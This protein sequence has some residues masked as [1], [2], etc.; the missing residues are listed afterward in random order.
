MGE[1]WSII[2]ALSAGASVLISL[3]IW[4]TTTSKTSMQRTIDAALMKFQIELTKE[5]DKRYLHGDVAEVRLKTIERLLRGRR[6]A[7]ESDETRI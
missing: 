5:L 1:T 4:A 3:G 2:A 6:L 7:D